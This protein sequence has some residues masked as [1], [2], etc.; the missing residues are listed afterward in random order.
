M[1]Q[2]QLLHSL[3]RN[4]QVAAVFAVAKS[5]VVHKGE[6]VGHK[7]LDPPQ[8]FLQSSPAQRPGVQAEVACNSKEEH[9]LDLLQEDSLS[10]LMLTPHLSNPLL[11][12]YQPENQKYQ[13]L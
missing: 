12:Q 6:T 8:A 4:L 13:F 1:F 10:G 11:G 5:A 9:Q 2:L 3:L 7:K